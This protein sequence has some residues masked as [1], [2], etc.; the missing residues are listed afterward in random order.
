MR[1][2]MMAAMTTVV[3][4]L[5]S[6][7]RAEFAEQFNYPN[8]GLVAQSGGKWQFFPGWT[9][10]ALVTNGSVNIT[11]NAG[12]QPDVVA[13][14][15]NIFATGDRAALSFD[16]YI[17]GSGDT[18]PQ[19]NMGPGSYDYNQFFGVFFND[20]AVGKLDLLCW[21][22]GGNVNIGTVSPDQWHHLDIVMAKSGTTV[23]LSAYL[24]GLPTSAANWTPLTDAQGF[25]RLELGAW[26]SDG[27]PNTYVL[28]DNVSLNNVPE[29]A[30]LALL[31]F[32]G[33]LCLV[34]RKR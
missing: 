21:G 16:A 11:D 5:A 17:H 1:T 25:N 18:Y 31:A 9:V 22:G 7:V 14:F 13:S 23:N 33:L 3:L 15:A 34:R 6:S 20:G 19:V 27:D 24:D 26:A 2:S 28:I 10:D 30:G 12:Q 8:G 29:P 4:V 32:G